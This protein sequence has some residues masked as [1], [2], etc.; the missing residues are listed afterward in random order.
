M[1][2]HREPPSGHLARAEARDSI[3]AGSDFG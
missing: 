3:A 2:S 1:L